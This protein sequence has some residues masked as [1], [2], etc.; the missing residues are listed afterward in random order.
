M[1]PKWL[2]NKI[3][4]ILQEVQD[5]KHIMK[6]VSMSQPP[7]KPAQ[8][9]A[10]KGK[11]YMAKMTKRELAAHLEQEIHSALGYKDG[12]L[13]E[14]R[15][16]AL[17]RYYGKRYGNEQEGRSQIVTRDVADVIEWIMPSLMKI[18]TSG[19][20]LSLIHI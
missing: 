14:Q 6:A 5:I 2:E 18:F 3:L 12:K 10:T 17:D 1:N 20:K 4:E 11:Q 9:P 7:E 16:D 8:E 13:T 15:S 19:D